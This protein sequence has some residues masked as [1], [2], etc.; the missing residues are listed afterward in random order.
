MLDDILMKK[1]HCNWFIIS[2]DWL[3]YSSTITSCEISMTCCT[4][5]YA[6]CYIKNTINA[7][8]TIHII[9]THWHLLPHWIHVVLHQPT[10]PH[11][12]QIQSI[13]PTRK[14]L[15]HLRVLLQHCA[16]R[17]FENL[18]TINGIQYNGFQEASIYY[19]HY[20]RNMQYLL[21]RPRRRNSEIGWCS[22]KQ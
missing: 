1:L 7:M 14:E 20:K 8:R 4:E 19:T 13:P 10:N 16:A 15:F 12:S 17:S 21:C 2:N 3:G 5:F 18:L 6:L 9:S 22:Y 11:Y